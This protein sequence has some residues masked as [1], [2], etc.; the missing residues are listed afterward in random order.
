MFIINEKHQKPVLGY[1]CRWVYKVIGHDKE[2]LQGVIRAAIQDLSYTVSPS[3]TSATGKYCC[4]NVE[5]VVPS[6]AARLA[7]YEALQSHP[8]VKI[9]L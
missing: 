8:A 1:P 3:H 2:I 7:I 4:L 9:V 5:M 6:E